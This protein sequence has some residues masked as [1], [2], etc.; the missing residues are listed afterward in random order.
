MTSELTQIDPRIDP[1]WPSPD[2]SPDW[3]PDALPDPY[4]G[5]QISLCQNKGL[6][7]VLLTIAESKCLPS[8]DWIRAPS[9]SQEYSNGC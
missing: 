6:F 8:K 5:P 2:P 3:S 1:E 4:P 9:Q 7:N